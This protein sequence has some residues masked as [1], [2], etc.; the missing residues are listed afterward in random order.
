MTKKKDFRRW[1]HAECSAGKKESQESCRHF[2]P[3]TEDRAEY[4]IYCC[5]KK[6]DDSCTFHNWLG[7]RSMA[8]LYEYYFNA[9]VKEADE[10]F[11]KNH[12]SSSW[13]N[14]KDRVIEFKDGSKAIIKLV[15]V[16][17]E[18]SD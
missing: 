16:C 3:D 12:V 9:G 10:F 11:E 7:E 6:L 5:H 1:V 4:D 14:E 2:V 15:P 8:G 13:L 18:S 17:E